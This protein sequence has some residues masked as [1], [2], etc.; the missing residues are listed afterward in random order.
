MCSEER[1]E[2]GMLFGFPIEGGGCLLRGI[3]MSSRKSI[4]DGRQ[5]SPCFAAVKIYVKIAIILS[6]IPIKSI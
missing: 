6:I 2:Q 3:S 5:F 1:E 4:S